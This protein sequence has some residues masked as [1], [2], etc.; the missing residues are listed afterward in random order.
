MSVKEKLS[1]M[2]GTRVTQE[3]YAFL[4]NVAEKKKWSIAQVLREIVREKMKMEQLLNKEKPR[5]KEEVE[6]PV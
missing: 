2:T 1:I 4:S 3:E 5:E 6:A